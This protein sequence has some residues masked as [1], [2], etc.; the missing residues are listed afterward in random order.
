MGEKLTKADMARIVKNAGRGSLTALQPSQMLDVMSEAWAARTLFPEE[1]AAAN[2]DHR[3][4]N[5]R[6]KLKRL[7]E[8]A[9]R[10]CR[11]ALAEGGEP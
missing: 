6:A 9:V 4:P 10:Y 8:R 11:A 3:G 2:R 5:R 7:R 1:W